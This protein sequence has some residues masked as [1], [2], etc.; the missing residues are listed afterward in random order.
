MAEKSQSDDFARKN[1]LLINAARQ[2][3]KHSEKMIM[4]GIRSENIK[5]IKPIH[6][7]NEKYKINVIGQTAVLYNYPGIQI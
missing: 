3:A 6:H 2:A 4:H 1:E 5:E 7:Q